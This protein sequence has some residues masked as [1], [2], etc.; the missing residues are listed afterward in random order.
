MI[1]N[2]IDTSLAVLGYVGLAAATLFVVTNPKPT[3]ATES[4]PFVLISDRI[5]T[6]TFMD[7]TITV[8]CT[9]RVMT[10]DEE[11]WLTRD[12]IIQQSTPGYGAPFFDTMYDEACN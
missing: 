12:Q 1:M 3:V 8:N 6:T 4:S 11:E 10:A 5:G 2:R 7:E 9:D